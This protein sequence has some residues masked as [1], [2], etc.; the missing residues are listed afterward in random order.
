MRDLKHIS[1]FFYTQVNDSRLQ[2]FRRM[3]QLKGTH[4]AGFIRAVLHTFAYRKPAFQTSL[5]SR[6]CHQRV[7][8]KRYGDALP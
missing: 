6:Q 5:R 8:T 3:L 7:P 1:T 4:I 2:G